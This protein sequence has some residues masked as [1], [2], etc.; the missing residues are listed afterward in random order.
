MI[1]RGMLLGTGVS[2]LFDMAFKIPLG[3]DIDGVVIGG[4]F[5]LAVCVGGSLLTAEK[6]F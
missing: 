5:C 2:F 1:N 3:L 6:S 4:L